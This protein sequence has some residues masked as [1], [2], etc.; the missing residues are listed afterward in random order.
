MIDLVFR[1]KQFPAGGSKTRADDFAATGG[2][3]AANAATAI[4]RLGGKATL[5]APLGGPERQDAIGDHI[6]GWLRSEGVDCSGI[7]RV[8]GAGSP[9]STIFIDASGER[10]IVSHRDNAFE[11]ARVSDPDALAKHADAVL[12]DNRSTDFALPV[13]QAARRRNLIVVLDG[14]RPERFTDDLLATP[15]HIVFSAETL[16]ANAGTDDLAAGLSALAAR[17]ASFVAV[18]DGANGMIWLEDGALRRMPAFAVKTVDTLAAG[19]VFHGGFTLALAEGR[20][21]EAAMRFAAA[22]AAIKCTRF[23]GAAGTPA[24]AEVETFLSRA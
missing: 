20:G 23:G 17:T 1:V 7:V 2:G 8:D 24:R 15:T 3:G 12:F 19:D 16:R 14:D 5:A 9:L 18:T 11:G 22:T 4:A 21:I 13:A 6:L 10:L